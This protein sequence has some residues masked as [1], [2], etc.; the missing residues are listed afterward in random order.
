MDGD[1]EEALNL[2]DGAD[3]SFSIDSVDVFSKLEYFPISHFV[4]FEQESFGTVGWSPIGVSDELIEAGGGC[5]HGALSE[6]VSFPSTRSL[7]S[8]SVLLCPSLFLLPSGSG[9][10]L[11]GIL[12]REG[13]RSCSANLWGDAGFFAN[14]TWWRGEAWWRRGAARLGAAGQQLLRLR[15]PSRDRPRE[16]QQGREALRGLE[17]LRRM[18]ARRECCRD[19]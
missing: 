12:L 2:V 6:G 10:I 13:G 3:K 19:C 14:A 1:I 17:L 5:G 15:Q 11:P 18:A 8:L 16:F 9:V 7:S 4:W